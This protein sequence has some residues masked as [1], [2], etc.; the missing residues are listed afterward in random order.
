MR[1]F[2]DGSKAIE[3]TAEQQ[4]VIESGAKEATPQQQPYTTFNYIRT[5]QYNFLMQAR[6]A[7]FLSKEKKDEDDDVPE[8]F[9]KFLKKTRKGAPKKETATSEEK[10]AKEKEG[11]K[12]AK[13]KKK[14]Q[15]DD[16]FSELEEDV[17]TEKDK[18]EADKG[19][20][21]GSAK[22]LKEFFFQP[23]GKDPK[24]ENVLLVAFLTGAFSYYLATMKPP[25]E[26]ITYPEFI[27]TYLAQGQ[28]AMITISEDKS[29]DTFKFRAVIETRSGKKVHMVLP[30]VENFLYKLDLAQ[31]EMGTNSQNFVPV[32]FA[33]QPVGGN[34]NFMMNYLIGAAFLALLVQLYRTMH[35]KGG[36]GSSSSGSKGGGLGGGGMGNMFQMGKSN[37]QVFGIDKKIKVRFKHVAGMQQAKTEVM[38]FVDFL[39]KPDKYKKLGAKIPR[40]ALLVGPPGTGKT[41]LAKA[42]AGEAGVPF[43]SISGSDFVE[44]FV[45]VGASRVRDLF[46]KAKEKSPSIIFIDEI[47]A[48]AKKRHGKF[49]GND[50]RDNTLNQLL[51][52]MDGFTTDQSVIIL[53]ATNRA[54]ILDSALTRP[55]RFDR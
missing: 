41:M 26:E 31:R 33:S 52:E 28:C 51:V 42:V 12:K 2:K 54:D 25:S 45:G 24:W 7:V 4:G 1:E 55:G 39:K 53:A 16:D 15:E 10:E 5:V 13:E 44:M 20:Q 17:E 43:F 35:G 14:A 8:G 49:G 27:N 29:S 9:R 32:K 18:K 37:V 6:N 48:V 3:L 21:S 50:E 22:K 47:D 11:D 38:E 30:Q 23:N 40:G 46:K 34:E 19:K 36:S